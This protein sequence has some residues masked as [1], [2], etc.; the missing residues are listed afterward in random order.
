MLSACVGMCK[1]LKVLVSTFRQLGMCVRFRDGAY[2]RHRMT[3]LGPLR[4]N[5]TMQTIL[6]VTK[7]VW[8][9]FDVG[10]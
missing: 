3:R 8:Q 1:A 7:N 6:S 9:Y 4:I 5:N 2:S 10:I